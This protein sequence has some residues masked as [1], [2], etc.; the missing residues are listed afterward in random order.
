VLAYNK[1]DYYDY[2]FVMLLKSDFV[3]PQSSE[4]ETGSLNVSSCVALAKFKVVKDM[5]WIT[6]HCAT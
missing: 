6:L 5:I 4:E 2:D 3:F 1:I